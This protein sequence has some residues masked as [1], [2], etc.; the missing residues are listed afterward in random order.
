MSVTLSALILGLVAAQADPQE[1]WKDA[2]LMLALRGMHARSTEVSRLELLREILERD[3]GAIAAASGANGSALSAAVGYRD[4]ECVTLLLEH[5]ADPDGPWAG[6]T[7]LHHAVE[8]REPGIVEALL[9]AGA[10]VR[11]R[12]LVQATHMGW[13][14]GMELLCDHGGEVNVPDDSGT[15]PVQAASE[16]GQEG[17]IGFLLA[18]GAHVSLPGVRSQPLHLAAERGHLRVAR[19]LLEHGAPPTARDHRDLSAVDLAVLRG[20]EDL[21]RLL[22]HHGAEMTTFVQVALA[23]EAG[24]GVIRGREKL[25]DERLHGE[26]LLHT[27]ARFGRAAAT[28]ELLAAGVDPTIAADHGPTALLVAA[29]RGDLAIARALL[30]GGADVNA[31]DS[32]RETPLHAAAGGAI[33]GR[34]RLTEDS[35]ALVEVLLEKGAEVDARLDAHLYVGRNLRPLHL[36]LRAERLD[37][38][39]ALLHAGA[40]PRIED[41]VIELSLGARARELLERAVLLSK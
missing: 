7:V 21:V 26:S 6:E 39:V 31:A 20:H 25:E 19:L 35:L 38:A 34:S 33:G 23:T 12:D 16:T 9:G 28:R 15:W 8:V 13:T 17:A 27:A 41:D 36:A 1:T 37:L 2:P 29:R 18:R 40:E 24:L 5:G 14:R 22:V 4:L 10:D 11:Q 32:S 30:E 3:S